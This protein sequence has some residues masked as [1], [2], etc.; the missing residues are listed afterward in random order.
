M[1]SAVNIEGSGVGHKLESCNCIV[2]SLGGCINNTLLGI[3]LAGDILSKSFRESISARL[4]VSCYVA[5]LG[6]L[7]LSRCDCRVV[8]GVVSA[9][10]CP[11]SNDCYVV[12]G[13]GL[14]KLRFPTCEGV[15]LLDGVCYGNSRA[16]VEGMRNAFSGKGVLVT[17]VEYL[18]D[19]ASVCRDL[20]GKNALLIVN[21]EALAGLGDECCGRTGGSGES[22]R[23][24]LAVNAVG[25]HY[26]G[27]DGISGVT[28]RCEH[29]L[30]GSV[31]GTHNADG[32]S[33]TCEGVAFLGGIRGGDDLLA[34]LSRNLSIL[35][36]VNVEYRV[37]GHQ[38]ESCDCVIDSGCCRIN[39]T[40]LGIKLAGDIHCESF[41]ES[42]SARLG[43]SCCVVGLGLLCMG[44]CDCR[45]VSGVVS[46]VLAPLGN[47]SQILC[48][49]GGGNHGAPAGEGV[50]LSG[51]R[52]GYLESCA[53]VNIGLC[54]V[55]SKLILVTAV[56]DLKNK[57]AVRK[58][59]AGKDT[60]VSNR[61]ALAGLGGYGNSLAGSSRLILDS[62]V[63]VVTVKTHDI[64]LDLVADGAC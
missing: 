38:L 57:A 4:G 8:S 59:F 34:D 1:N 17:A 23:G 62:S 33:P 56:V 61:E 13:H 35:Y 18:E 32:G 45:V 2:D 31:C 42:I 36:A 5:I 52:I 54:A 7:R 37:V 49:H 60:V 25:A 58:D 15:V 47:E 19:K 46:A 48:R 12:C 3:K 28:C 9:V 39:N 14:G 22:I 51:S 20:A 63:A 41:R 55:N 10:L 44:C 30:E 29:C 26:I 11:L 50:A 21:R 43:V 53:E 27:I 16:I 6:L 24:R 40:L 64:G